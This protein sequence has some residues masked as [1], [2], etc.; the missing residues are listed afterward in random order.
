MKKLI[1]SIILMTCALLNGC[2]QPKESAGS[3][4]FVTT[5]DYPPFEYKKNGQL[6][7]FD[8]ELAELVAQEL[9]LEAHF[10]DMPFGS[11]MLAVA[12]NMADAAIA[13]MTYTP[14]RANSFDFSQPY[15]V[16]SLAIISHKRT[17]IYKSTSLEGKIIACQIA[18]AMEAWLKTHAP[19]TQRY[20][21]DTNPQAVEALKAGHVQG[22]LIDE[23]Q[24]KA[25]VSK[26][27]TLTYELVAHA[28]SGY[29]IVLKKNSPLT[30]K[31][32]QALTN[33]ENNG[34]LAALKQKYLEGDLWSS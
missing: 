9:G 27:P 12:N 11:L 25:F 14:E 23:V 15:Y 21:V 16:E 34:K 18:S 22:V 19:S 5:S 6:V 29:G 10:Q 30:A 3:L 20:T 2:D 26:N 24:A 1:I 32:N 4:L 31:M 7:G 8:V 33:L 17:P 13:T 28:D